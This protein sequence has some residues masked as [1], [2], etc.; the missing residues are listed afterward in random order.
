MGEQDCPGFGATKAHG[1][2]H[3]KGIRGQRSLQCWSQGGVLQVR[4]EGKKSL[5]TG[6]TGFEGLVVAHTTFTESAK[7]DL[8]HPSA[9]DDERRMVQRR[10]V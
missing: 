6:T 1:G 3:R 2:G 4:A 7:Q 5:A 10:K 8:Q 9:E